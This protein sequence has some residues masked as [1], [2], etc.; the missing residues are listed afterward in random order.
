MRPASGFAGKSCS[1]STG[2]KSTQNRD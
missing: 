1:V 2:G